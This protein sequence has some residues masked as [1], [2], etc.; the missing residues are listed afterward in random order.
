V[1]SDMQ[2]PDVTDAPRAGSRRAPVIAAAVVL[3]ALIALVLPVFSTLQPG[4]YARYASLRPRMDHWRD[5]THGRIACVDCHMDPGVG[6][7]LSFAARSVP[8]FYAQ[9]VSGPSATNLL[10]LPSRAA[11]QRCHTDYR[12]VS[13]NGDLL[14]PHRAHVEV[15]HIQCVVCHKDLVHS[16]GTG[17]YNQPKMATCLTLCHNGVKATDKCDKCHTRKEVPASHHA[18]DWL[19]VHGKTNRTVECGKCHAW[20]PNYCGDCHKKRPPSHVGNWKTA[21]QVEAKV[22]GDGCLVC[23]SKTNFCGKCH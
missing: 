4:Y 17:T 5:S 8:T 19:L 3:L 18:K 23:H 22:H 10:Q 2:T 9:L 20:T 1:S 12:Q 7:F 16:A 21:H 15:L 13:P 6:G 14:I 11:C